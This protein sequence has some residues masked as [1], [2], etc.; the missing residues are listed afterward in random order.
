MEKYKDKIKINGENISLLSDLL[1]KYE[2]IFNEAG[3]SE[4]V[5]EAYEF[6]K[7]LT[8][9]EIFDEPYSKVLDLIRELEPFLFVDQVFL[10]KDG[11]KGG[12]EPKAS[13]KYNGLVLVSRFRTLIDVALIYEG[14]SIN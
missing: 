8:E 6:K 5:V 12:K 1:K 2:N 11:S 7:P 3:V 4:L 10:K 9:I 14:F 13:G